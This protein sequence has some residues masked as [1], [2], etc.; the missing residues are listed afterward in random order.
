MF[1]ISTLIYLPI[2]YFKL[3]QLSLAVIASI[4]GLIRQQG[5]IKLSKD[6]LIAS[7]MSDFGSSLLYILMV[8]FLENPSMA[9]FLPLDVYFAIGAC[10]FITRS[11]MQSL[12]RFEKVK[13]IT[14]IILGTKEDLK[15]ARVYIEVFVFFYLIILTVMR[16][17]GLLPVL[18]A[19]NYLRIRG[20]SNVGKQV[21]WVLKVDLERVLGRVPFLAKAVGWFFGVLMG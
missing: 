4:M 19:F 20:M 9:F 7:I 13:R 18:V 1:I 5:Q 11:K 10:E 16:K 12:L 17:I 2:S 3:V 15:K 21:Y 14:G 8:A 6:Y